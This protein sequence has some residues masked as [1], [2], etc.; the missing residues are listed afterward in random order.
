[1]GA[2]VNLDL[3]QA[4]Q[5]GD[6]GILGPGGYLVVNQIDGERDGQTDN[7]QTERKRQTESEKDENQK[8]TRE[9]ER[10]KTRGIK[11]TGLYLKLAV[12]CRG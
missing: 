10:A 6:P 3:L 4:L 12:L 2:T 1:M 9:N 8:T 5:L 11:K 7:R